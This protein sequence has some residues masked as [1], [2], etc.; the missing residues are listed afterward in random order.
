VYKKAVLL[1]A[2]QLFLRRRPSGRRWFRFRLLIVSLRRSHEARKLSSNGQLRLLDEG[3]IQR[4]FTVFVDGVREIDVEAA[5]RYAKVAPAPDLLVYTRMGADVVLRRLAQRERGLS[6][7][8]GR[9]GHGRAA[10]VLAEAEQMLDR[11]TSELEQQGV[12]LIRVGPCE[13]E[14][15]ERQVVDCVLSSRA[16]KRRDPRQ[17]GVAFAHPG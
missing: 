15:A 11:V 13:T 6:A 8:L 2:K 3:P 12:A 7:R 5:L 14:R 4:A 9:E 1:A 10:R 17:T 16:D